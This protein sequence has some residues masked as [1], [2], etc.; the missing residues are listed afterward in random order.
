MKNVILLPLLLLML[1]TGCGTKLPKELPPL[2][3]C[4]VTVTMENTPLQG[5]LVYLK[6]EIHPNIFVSGITDTTGTAVL[7][8]NGLYRGAPEGQYKVT[9]EKMVSDPNWKPKNQWEKE[10]L[11]NIVHEKY[12]IMESSPLECSIKKGN[13]QIKFEIESSK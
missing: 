10:Q 13:N 6:T 12:S 9:I 8:T 5:G 4:S 11:K 7:Q 3:F 1:Q 2:Y